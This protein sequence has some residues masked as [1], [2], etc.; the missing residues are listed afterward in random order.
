ML[1]NINTGTDALV[2]G[3]NAVDAADLGVRFSAFRTLDRFEQQTDGIRFGMVSWPG[4]YLAEADAARFGL[5]YDGLY[6]PAFG[7]PGLSDMFD[8]ANEHDAGVNVILPTV[9]YV[10]NLDAMRADI[11]S[12]M[13]DM[14]SGH[15]GELP[16][17][18]ILNIGSEYY[19][20]FTPIYGADG[21]ALYG[22]VASSMVHEINACLNDPAINP[23]GVEIDVSVQAGR[24][25]AEDEEIRDSFSQDD[26]A[27]IDTVLHHRYP[28]FAEGVD[29]TLNQF[30][31][32]YEAWVNDV[33]DA[34]G[35]RPELN[36][37]EWNVASVTRDEALTKYI[38]DMRAEGVTVHRGDVDLDARTNDDFEQYWQDLLATRD[39]GIEAPRLYLEL[40]SEYQAEG[41]GAASLHAFDMQHAG[42]AT[43]VDASGHPVQFIGAEAIGMIYESVEGLTVMDI[44]TQNARNDDL[45]T[46]GFENQDRTVLFLSADDDA[47][48]GQVTLDV[49]GLE[50]GYHAVWVESLTAEVPENWMEEFGVVD[51]PNIDESAEANTYALGIR[52]DV[53]FSVKDGQISFNMDSEG[54]TVRIIVAN[55]PEEAAHIAEWAGEPDMI[56]END[57][58]DE[59]ATSAI[60]DD[61]E[62]TDAVHITAAADTAATSSAK[63]VVA[64]HTPTNNFFDNIFG[65]S[66]SLPTSVGHVA[67]APAVT[68]AQ[69]VATPS[70]V[71]PTNNPFNFF[72]NSGLNTGHAATQPAAAPTVAAPAHDFFANIFGKSAVVGGSM[73]QHANDFAGLPMIEQD[74]EE[75]D[76]ANDHEDNADHEH[77]FNFGG[78]IDAAASAGVVGM[79]A[80]IAGHLF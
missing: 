57:P 46:Y 28:G 33:T 5:N 13:T 4:G 12:F 65:G 16:K 69:P 20:H 3:A 10:G 41:M 47:K 53:N 48:I 38:R 61:S 42:R 79:L 45:W 21:A 58:A 8:F 76:A 34:G 59:S 2:E 50:S 56:V 62:M 11:R 32:I 7:Q 72:G 15:Y 51:N 44:S 73:V 55:T 23:N 19:A 14:L 39:Y 75:H 37:A 63:T 74:D 40:F 49:E 71:A 43:F 24:S 30:H 18:V 35:D 54:E 29:Y 80:A 66:F 52:S 25:M 9:R 1:I 78:M 67:V 60:A 31:P 22:E 36:L 77:D 64:T 70:H 68:T 27:S 17:Q 26:L 6:N